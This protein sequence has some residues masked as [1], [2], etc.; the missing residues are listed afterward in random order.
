VGLISQPLIR[1]YPFQDPSIGR[2]GT[3]VEYLGSLGNWQLEAALFGDGDSVNALLPTS[4]DGAVRLQHY[5][6]PL[7]LGASV[8]RE[9]IPDADPDYRGTGY[10]YGVDF[11]YGRPA[12]ILRGEV[13]SGHV[14]EGDPEGFY[15]DVLYHPTSL[16]RL[17]FVARAEAVSGQ[18]RNSRTYQQYTIGLKW[19]LVRDTTLAINQIFDSPRNQFSLQ[20]TALFLWHTHR[21]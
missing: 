7:I 4:G 12:L 17:T 18:P 11:R 6:G 14:P 20:G 3:G 5:A 13:V 9:R 15:V 16:G 19:Q 8:L 10:F 21:L 1:Y 2:S